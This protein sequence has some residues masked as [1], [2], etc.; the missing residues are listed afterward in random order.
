MH[1]LHLE[2]DLRDA[3]IIR[4][5]LE[6]EGIACRLTRVERRDEF[7]DALARQDIDLIV[8]DF[9]LACFDG[10]SALQIALERRPELPFIFVSRTPGEELAVDAV[11]M[12][13]TDY[14][15]KERP[16]RIAS[17]VR[18][19]L[20]EAAEKSQR[21]QADQQLRQ[22]EK[23]EAVGRL[24]SSIAHD[25]NNIL[26]GIGAYAEMLFEEAP[27]AS[28]LMRYAQNVLTATARGHR[29]LEQIHAYGVSPPSQ[30]TPGAVARVVP[31]A[32]GPIRDS[33][34]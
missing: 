1:I 16:A 12:G 31:E 29:L 5:V 30:R 9:S 18:R 15:L 19:A 4:G 11:K 33:L 8:A 17:A 26:G 21:R 32:P 28:P 14:V 34:P 10:C 6:R 23:M 7:V 22:A 13:A 3:D 27:C 24:A 20:R 25:F 2:D